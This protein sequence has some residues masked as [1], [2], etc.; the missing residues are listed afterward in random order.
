MV[1][2]HMVWSWYCDKLDLLRSCMRCWVAGVPCKD[3]GSAAVVNSLLCVYLELW[4]GH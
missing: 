3:T 2:V 4:C 1:G